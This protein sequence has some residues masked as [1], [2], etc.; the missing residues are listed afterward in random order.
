MKPADIRSKTER[1]YRTH[2]LDFPYPKPYCED[3]NNVKAILLG[4][5]PSN[6]HNKRLPYVF[7]IG[8]GDPVFTQFISSWKKSLKA[9]GLD[10]G[11]VYIQNL[12][13]NY[14]DAETSENKIW[15]LIAELWIPVLKKE[16]EIFDT[17]TPVLLTSEVLYEV[18]LKN[19]KEKRKAVDFYERKMPI[20]I[21]ASENKL[22]RPLI[23]LYRHYKYNI[24]KSE[25]AEYRDS[26][27]EFLYD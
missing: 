23:P 21:S 15:K 27:I 8:S 25:W 12:C 1:K 2:I 6:N 14:F 22:E 18:L 20:P 10:F 16:L 13:Q 3:Q 17:S 11:C 4:C 24:E 19:P 5:D 9:I 26:I 7:A